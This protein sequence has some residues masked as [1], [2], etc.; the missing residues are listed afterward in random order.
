MITLVNLPQG[1]SK[2]E[3][4]YGSGEKV[5]CINEKKPCKEC[6]KNNGEKQ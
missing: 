6:A 1:I 3:F 5:T 2:V 4:Y